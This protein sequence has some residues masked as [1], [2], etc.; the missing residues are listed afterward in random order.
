M[1]IMIKP[2]L[3]PPVCSGCG[4]ALLYKINKDHKNKL[5][6]QWYGSDP[7]L[8]KCTNCGYITDIT[9]R[10]AEDYKHA[11]YEEAGI[12]PIGSLDT[13]LGIWRQD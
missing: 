2:I 5:Q 6:T 13:K 1:V 10:H 9:A 11:H 3:V 7:E 4:T 8:Y 12:D